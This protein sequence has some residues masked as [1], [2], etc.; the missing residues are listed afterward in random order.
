M[1][2]VYMPDVT[3]LGSDVEVRGDEAHHLTRVLRVRVSDAVHVFDGRGREWRAHVGS[4]S[5]STVSLVVEREVSPVPEP[6]VAVTLAVGVLKGDQM[7]AVVRDAT[8]MGVTAIR[9]TVTDHVV[10]PSKA[11]RDE[12]GVDRWHR[13]AV[14][15]A[16]QCGRAVVPTISPVTPLEALWSQ[17]G[18]A[19]AAAMTLVCVEPAAVADGLLPDW[20]AAA[21]PSRALVLVGPEGGWSAGELASF[22]ARRAH[23][24]SLGPRTLRA[25]AA[26][27]VALTLLWATWGW[28]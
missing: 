28:T 25:E 27:A 21:R 12:R 17:T 20:R 23:G 26:P 7:D 22:A 15:A 13:V 4:V 2:R 10:V 8:V 6:L 11:W 16:K 18:D 3:G 5:R 14:A 1:T 19:G 9:P 24:V